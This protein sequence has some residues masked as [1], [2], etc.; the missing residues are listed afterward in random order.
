MSQPVVSTPRHEV[1]DYE[2]LPSTVSPFTHMV[3][4]A[5][6]GIAEHTF[7][8]PLDSIKTRMQVLRPDPSAVYTGLVHATGI[9]RS[10][11]GLM[12]LWHGVGSVIIGAGPAHGLYFAAYEQGKKLMLREGHTAANDPVRVGVA[13]AFATAVS[14]GFMTPF[15]VIKQ[16]MQIHGSSHSGVLS[17]ARS[18]LQTEGLSGFFVSYP[19]TLILNVPFHM[20][21]FPLYEA[22]RAVLNPDGR[23]SP[24]AHIISGGLAGGVAAFCTTPI[25]VIKTTLQ[26][27]NLIGGNVSSMSEAIRLV[28][29]EHG[30]RGF[31]RGAIPR[32]LTFVPGTALCW[33]VYEYFKWHLSSPSLLSSSSSS[34]DEQ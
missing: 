16:R 28:L 23:Y 13:G 27:R 15:D 7:T 33:M 21:Q 25:D 1:I 9:I 6:A 30:I 8:F 26:T 12:R 10:T 3:A 24:V 22:S 2:C 20:I 34:T 5:L 32:A 29:K 17:C 11:E 19:T 31:L 14:D 4:G 18:I